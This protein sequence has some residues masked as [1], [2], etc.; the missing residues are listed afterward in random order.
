LIHLNAINVVAWSPT[1]FFLTGMLYQKGPTK[2]SKHADAAACASTK[3][4]TFTI[5]TSSYY[6]NETRMVSDNSPSIQY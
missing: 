3:S 5:T 4:F 1:D 2:S 6:G